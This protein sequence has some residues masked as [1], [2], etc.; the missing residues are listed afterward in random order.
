MD[1][2]LTCRRLGA[3]DVS[4]ICLEEGG[5]MP[6]FPAEI[7]EALEEGITIMDCWGPRRI[8]AGRRPGI[9]DRAFALPEAL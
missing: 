5:R 1:V 6:A 3:A 4:L 2:A 9:P 8:H 7:K